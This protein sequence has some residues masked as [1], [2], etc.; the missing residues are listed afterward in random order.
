MSSAL[1]IRVYGKCVAYDRE[2][3]EE[4]TS[5][6]VLAL[7]NGHCYKKD[8]N[9]DCFSYWLENEPDTSLISNAG[10]SGGYLTFEFDDKQGEL[11]ASVVYDLERELLTTEIAALV[12]YTYGQCLDGIGS[13]F[14]QSD[15]EQ[16][17]VDVAP[18]AFDLNV[19]LIVNGRPLR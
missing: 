14:Q 5:P 3:E 4:T 9:V 7:I 18:M 15:C 17:P 8:E 16:F 11:I 1:Q 6:D 19:E 12:E 13:N 2:T 10:I